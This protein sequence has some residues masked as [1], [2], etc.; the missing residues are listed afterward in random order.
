MATAVD[1]GAIEVETKSVLQSLKKRALESYRKAAK[2]SGKSRFRHYEEAAMIDSKIGMFL[3][4][5]QWDNAFY[6]LHLY[7]CVTLPPN[8]LARCTQYPEKAKTVLATLTMLEDRLNLCKNNIKARVREEMAKKLAAANVEKEK[9]APAADDS[10]TM[11]LA[12]RFA[13]LQQKT[14]ADDAGAAAVGSSTIYTGAVVVDPP[15]APSAPLPTAP[16][17]DDDAKAAPH[18]ARKVYSDDVKN[19]AFAALF[20]SSAP[21][22]T[23]ASSKQPPPVS[24]SS[25]LYPTDDTRPYVQ[26][27]VR[28]RTPPA[29]APSSG[30]LYTGIPIPPRAASVSPPLPHP[31]STP[32]QHFSTTST[33][34]TTTL[35]RPAPLYRRLSNTKIEARQSQAMRVKKVQGDGHCAFRCIAQ[36]QCGGMLS[37]DQELRTALDLRRLACRLLLAR[38]DD[39]TTGVGLSVEQM[40]LIKDDSVGSFEEYVD[41]MSRSAFAGE[42]EFW[43]LSEELGTPIAVFAWGEGKQ[44]GKLEHLITYDPERRSA[45][46]AQEEP[47]RLLWQRGTFSEHGNHYD[48]LLPS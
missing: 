18:P 19:A 10:T 44:A 5:K 1:E 15:P 47:V 38:R 34:A 42:T 28:A 31:G 11:S 26:T 27:P 7:L 40:T 2:K 35:P 20:G 22:L 45:P 12:D 29:P 33:K 8:R 39:E 43:L 9:P 14:F 36:G 32:G 4:A 16:P 21:K 17:A 25:S 23:A 24:S 3:S 37:Q 48:L 30:G 41:R 46:T 6:C 13:A